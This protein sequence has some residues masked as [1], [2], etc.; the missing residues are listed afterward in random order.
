[1]KQGLISIEITNSFYKKGTWCI[2]VGDIR[3]SIESSN[4]G[5]KEMFE[6]IEEEVKKLEKEVLE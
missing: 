1:M 6:L 2:R 5:K 4:I 3:G